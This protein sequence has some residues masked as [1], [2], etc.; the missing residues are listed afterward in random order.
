MALRRWIGKRAY[1]LYTSL[2]FQGDQAC[3]LM[4]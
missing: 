2:L 4:G 1:N 3:R